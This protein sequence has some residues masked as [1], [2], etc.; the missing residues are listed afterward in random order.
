MTLDE[1]IDKLVED[2]A[3]YDKTIARMRLKV[4][5]QPGE[6]ISCDSCSK[7][8]CCYQYVLATPNESMVIARHLKQNGRDT[9]TLR[10]RLRELGDGMASMS[11]AAWFNTVTPCVFLEAD[12]C[13]IYEVR[14][15]ACRACLVLSPAEDCVPPSGKRTKNVNTV[16]VIEANLRQAFHLSEVLGHADPRKPAVMP[17][18]LM[19]LR[20][21]EAADMPDEDAGIAHIYSDFKDAEELLS[22]VEGRPLSPDQERP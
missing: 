7:P 10:A 4:V 17:L 13:S 5:Y 22:S 18:P 8:G 9:P 20:C 6:S 15:V 12:Y 1:L 11:N 14:P 21:L 16:S 2:L 19:V 3:E